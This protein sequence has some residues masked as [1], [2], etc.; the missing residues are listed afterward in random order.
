MIKDHFSLVRGM[1]LWS[2]VQSFL[3]HINVLDLPV[4]DVRTSDD[5]TEDSRQQTDQA[6]SHICIHTVTPFDRF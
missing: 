3:F 4:H 5:A 1:S 2:E 6:T